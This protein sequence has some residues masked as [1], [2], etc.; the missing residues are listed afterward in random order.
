MK[1]WL[2]KTEPDVYG[3]DDLR[4]AG[5]DQWDGIRNYQAR[6]LIRD[7]MSIGDKILI[8]HSRTNPIGVVGEAEI[9]STAYPDPTQFDPKAKYFDSKSDPDNPRWLLVD[10]KYIRHYP[11]MITL[12]QLKATPGLENMMVTK[13][14]ARLSI[15]PVEES[16]WNI[17]QALAGSESA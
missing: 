5:T 8:Y 4:Q 13:R 11:E 3:I 10:I 1:Y 2:F 12:K 6:N 7:Q 9:A 16:E 15:Q 14:G 17:V